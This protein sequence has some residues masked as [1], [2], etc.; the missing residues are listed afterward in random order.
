MLLV[1]LAGVVLALGCAAAIGLAVRPTGPEPVP[2]APPTAGTGPTADG[3]P[4]EIRPR[5]EARAAMVL[6]RWD[7]RRAAAYAVGDVESLRDLYLPGRRVGR[8]DA[9]LLQAYV[10]RDL[11]VLG[12]RP[13]VLEVTVLHQ[14]PGRLRLRVRDRLPRAVVVARGSP[15][16]QRALPA[17]GP[18]LHE[19]RLVRRTGAWKVAAVRD[20]AH[21]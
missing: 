1:G 20:A 5:P 17:G 10:A 2:A 9:A 3:P 18:Q 15:P 21:R 14:S 16:V 11:T 7:R 4:G 8:A 12:A 6:G 13:Q 19:V